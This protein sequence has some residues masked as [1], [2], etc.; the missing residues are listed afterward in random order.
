MSSKCF[1]ELQE[2]VSKNLSKN[3]NKKLLEDHIKKY[4]SSITT[5]LASGTLETKP[6]F[7]IKEDQGVVFKASGLTR[8]MVMDVLRRTRQRDVHSGWKVWQGEQ[9]LAFAMVLRYFAIK[10]DRQM[11]E[12]MKIYFTLLFYSSLYRKY[13]TLGFAKPEVMSYTIANMSN[14]FDIKK[15]GSL[16]ATLRKISD[17]NHENAIKRLVSTSDNDIFVYQRDLRTRINGFLKNIYGLYKNNY[18]TGKYLNVDKDQLED[19]E[20]KTYTADRSSDAGAV[21][22]AAESFSIWFVTNRLNAKI[23]KVC[24]SVSPD[25]SIFKLESTLNAIKEDD[26]NRIRLIVQSILEVLSSTQNDNS[27]K[28]VHSKGFPLFCIRLLSKSNSSNES[29]KNIK[30]NIDALLSE[31]CTT[32]RETKREATKISYRKA[33][34]TYIA[35]GLQV[36]RK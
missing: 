4:L 24:C 34:I 23:I 18:T 20:G 32:F 22:S 17:N 26:G 10:K 5:I 8:P 33:L 14:K 21:F 15:L 28:G 6:N 9:Y 12:L 16:M 31:F 1:I 30:Y 19:E 11:T 35:L 25:I 2:T 13:F 7:S 27:F 36:Q 29:I 3:E